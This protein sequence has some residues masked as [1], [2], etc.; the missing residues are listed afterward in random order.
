M[1]P[2]VG[3]HDVCGDVVDDAVDGVAD[4]LM[5]RHQEGR[6]REDDHRALVVQPEDIVVDPDG[7]EL[8]E[9][10]DLLEETQHLPGRRLHT[11]V[12][13]VQKSSTFE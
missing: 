8:Q 9:A 5:G 7:V 12:V 10:L 3:V 2:A 6:D 11:H 13:V 1:D 4:V